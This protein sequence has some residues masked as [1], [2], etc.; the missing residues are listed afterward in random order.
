MVAHGQTGQDRPQQPG[1]QILVG[2]ILLPIALFA[3]AMFG[4]GVN[5]AHAA[6]SDGKIAAD[7]RAALTSSGHKAKWAAS[8][9]GGT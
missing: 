7:L 6:R 3:V 8:A 2:R 9:Q 1:W 5:A 4:A